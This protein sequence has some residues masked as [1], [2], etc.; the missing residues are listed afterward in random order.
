M[1]RKVSY[2]LVFII[3][4]FSFGNSV[5]AAQ[6]LT[7][8]YEKGKNLTGNIDKVVLTQDSNG[9]QTLY[10]NSEDVDINT[11]KNYWYIVDGNAF[12]FDKSGE[13]GV[14]L[15][16][17]GYLTECP[18]SKSTNWES[19]V[20]FYG[21]DNGG[22]QK[23]IESQSLKKVKVPSLS[24]G[25]GKIPEL[26]CVYKKGGNDIDKV[27]ITQSTTG[28]ITMYKNKKDVSIS[29]TGS[30]WYLSNDSIT[31]DSTTK[32]SSTGYLTKCPTSK[33]TSGW[34]TGTITF[35]Y[36]SNYKDSNSKNLL[37]DEALEIKYSKVMTIQTSKTSSPNGEL[38][39]DSQANSSKQCT[40]IDKNDKWLHDHEGYTLSCLYESTVNGYGLN[41]DTTSGCHIIQI[42]VGNS[43]VNVYDSEATFYKNSNSNTLNYSFKS[44]SITENE[45]ISVNGGECPTQIKVKRNKQITEFGTSLDTTI[46]FSGTGEIYTLVNA[47]GKNLVTGAEASSEFSFNIN[48]N[49]FT[50]AT[51]DELFGNNSELKDLLKNLIMAVK[52]LIP[53]I[54]LVLGSLD[55]AQAVFSSNEDGIKK[56]QQKFIKRLIIAVVIFLIPNILKLLLTIAHS[57]WPAIDADL[58]GLI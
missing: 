55:F 18:K 19:Y 32:R 2:L 52:I 45:A 13:N 37:G 10:K 16:K 46:S 57:V 8:I 44:D 9:V 51:C 49:T 25:S 5:Y 50:I 38:D 40:Q 21:S 11:K 7:C 14:K 6:E 34:G 27:A 33:S 42:N 15:D 1:N 41:T 53:I 22:N 47:E 35:Y 17:N 56:A 48:F 28:K 12:G 24:S 31:W 20:T 36:D 30:Y 54:L 3:M 58:C 4:L 39:Y 23:L 29:D 26:T 43:G